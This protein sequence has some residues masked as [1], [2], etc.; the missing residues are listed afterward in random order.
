ME[1]RHIML[2]PKHYQQVYII[3]ESTRG[4]D[5]SSTEQYEL[6]VSSAI[7]ADVQAACEHSYG[8][9][10]VDA[11][12]FSKSYELYTCE[13]CGYSYKEKYFDKKELGQG[14]FNSY[15]CSTGKGKLYLSWL[16]ITDA[17]GYHIRYS[18]NKSLKT[19]IILKNIKGQSTSSKTISK[20]SR[21]KRYY[22]Q[23]RPYIKSAGKAT[24][25]K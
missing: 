12:Y 2:F 21:K 3:I 7:K 20:L 5:A 4:G 18:T 23:V 22:V 8:S 1:I 19:G 10:Y 25:G 15:N 11:T 17:T 16:T 14:H 9:Y 24:Y 13:K 6:K